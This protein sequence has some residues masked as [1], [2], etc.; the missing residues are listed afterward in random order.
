MIHSSLEGTYHSSIHWDV[1][2]PTHFLLHGYQLGAWYPVRFSFM[3]CLDDNR[4]QSQVKIFIHIGE[5]I[6]AC[7]RKGWL[8]IWT[9]RWY[10]CI[11]SLPYLPR[12]IFFL[13]ESWLYHPTLETIQWLTIALRI[14]TKFL[15]M[16]CSILPG[17][18]PAD[19]SDINSYWNLLYSLF[20][21]QFLSFRNSRVPSSALPQDFILVATVFQ[22]ALARSSDN[23][24]ISSGKLFSDFAS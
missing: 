4:G 19:S 2:L 23:L 7:C 1:L 8:V 10:L 24:H 22:N 5:V 15:D 16:V 9:G 11:C 21:S 14:E 12:Y 3:R 17:L 6:I 13:M 20:L 18:T